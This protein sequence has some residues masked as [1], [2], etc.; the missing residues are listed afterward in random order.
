MKRHLTSEEVLNLPKEEFVK[1][2]Q[3]IEEEKYNNMHVIEFANY[4]RFNFD[5]KVS[6][7]CEQLNLIMRNQ[8]SSGL[9]EYLTFKPIWY[10]TMKRLEPEFDLIIDKVFEKFRLYQWE[11]SKEEFLKRIGK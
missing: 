8:A 5:E 1:Y 3:K 2:M 9:D 6:A 7:W 4:D 11:W 10:K